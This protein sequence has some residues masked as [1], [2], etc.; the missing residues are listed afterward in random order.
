MSAST[1]VDDRSRRRPLERPRLRVP[2]PRPASTKVDDRSR[3]RFPPVTAFL[4]WLV[5]PQRRSTTEVVDGPSAE[6]ADRWSEMP[7]RRSTTEVVDGPASA[8]TPAVKPQRRS[9]TEVVDGQTGHVFGTIRLRASTKV[10]DR[11]RRRRPATQPVRQPDGPASTKVDDRSRRRALTR[12]CGC[13]RIRLNEGRRPKSSTAGQPAH[14]RLAGVW[15]STKVDDRSRRRLPAD[16]TC[17]PGAVRLNEGRR[18]KSSTA[19]AAGVM[20]G[21]FPLPQRRSTTEVVDG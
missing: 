9:T 13:M 7:Q 6:Q 2:R 19:N 5:L 11:S 3:R 10:D 18:P 14:R 15:A 21:L 16:R 17:H 4:T 8:F 12:M 1:K 20:G